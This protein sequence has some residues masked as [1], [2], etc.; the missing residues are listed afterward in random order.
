MSWSV[1]NNKLQINVQKTIK[2]I[3]RSPYARDF[4]TLQPLPLIEQVTKLLIKRGA[5]CQTF[6]IDVF[7]SAADKNNSPIDKQQA[8]PTFTHPQKNMPSPKH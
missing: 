3:F 4:T 7:I 2:L 8:L 5:C 1:A 6:T